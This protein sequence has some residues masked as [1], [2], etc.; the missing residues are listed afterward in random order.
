MRRTILIGGIGVAISIASAISATAQGETKFDNYN[1]IP[2]YPV[3]YANNS[4]LLPPEDASKAGQGVDGTFN[5]ELGYYIGVTSEPAQLTLLPS[6][7]ESI[8]P[9]LKEPAGGV[10]A[11]T[12][13]YFD[14]IVAT[15]PGYPST[16]GPVTFGVIAWETTGQYGG[17]TYATSMLKTVNPVLW[18]ESS[19]AYVGGPSNPEIPQRWANLPP[20]FAPVQ[21]D[22]PE[23]SALA[24]LGLGSVATLLI[25]RRR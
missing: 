6:T 22:A 21:F 1:S 15:I 17:S 11:P 20:N 3:T 24:L 4:S 10:G 18:T 7:I 13:G 12:T 2:Y 9:N 16:H 19:I 8:N 5:V 23:P 14:T 25:R